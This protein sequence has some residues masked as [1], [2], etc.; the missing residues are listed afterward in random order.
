M[1]PG[2]D[3]A[4]STETGHKILAAAL[5]LFREE[6]FDQA[7]MR[8]IAD[9]AG[10]ATGA[11]Y[12]YYRSKEAII[13]SF[14]QRSCDEMQPLI[15]AAVDASGGLEDR[16]RALI[17][18]KID[19]FTPNRSVLRALLRNGA[20]PRHPLSPFGTETRAIRNVDLEWFRKI[21]L[22]CGV[23]IP[24]DLAPHVPG[25]LWLLQMGIIYFWVIDESPHQKRTQKLLD[26]ASKC[27]VFLI[28][29]A[30]LPWM[31]PVRK[32]VVELIETV[33]EAG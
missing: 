27:V 16:L 24:R 13:L 12:Y 2:A 22:D 25:V 5:E 18:V 31:R 15:Q 14:Y 10:M 19:Y 23:R 1:T 7:T 3:S 20:D 11:A 21:L 33:K 4:K 32:T 8:G 29:A 26:L 17:R 9:K 30:G 6:G 28:R